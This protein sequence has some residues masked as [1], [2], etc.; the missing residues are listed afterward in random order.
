MISKGISE[1]VPPQMKILNVDNQNHFFMLSQI[2]YLD[3]ILFLI[4][5]IRIHVS[6]CMTNV[7]LLQNTGTETIKCDLPVSAE[8]Q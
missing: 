3:D 1:D 5:L 2:S 7:I 6:N 8:S 4:T